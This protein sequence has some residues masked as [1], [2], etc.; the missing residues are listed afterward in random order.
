MRLWKP[1]K[2]HRCRI[3][4]RSIYFTIVQERQNRNQIIVDDEF[5]YT[6]ATQI[7]KKNNDDD[8]DTE[9]HTINEC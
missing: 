5:T 2:K 7:S 9:P 8:W 4:K 6:V 1:L 3:M